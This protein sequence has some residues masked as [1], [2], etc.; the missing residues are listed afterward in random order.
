MLYTHCCAFCVDSW[1][2]AMLV[3]CGLQVSLYCDMKRTKD[4]QLI[5]EVHA[6]R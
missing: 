4:A 2:A 6:L 3:V 5:E 1:T